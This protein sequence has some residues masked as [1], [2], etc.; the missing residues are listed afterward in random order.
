MADSIKGVV[1]LESKDS[2]QG[3]KDDQVFYTKD[4]LQS[5]RLH[6]TMYIS[7][8]QT[9]GA[10]HLFKEAFAN[11]VDECNN[12]NPHWD[13][14][15]KKISVT[16]YENQRKFVVMDNGR[17][18]PMDILA[19][20][21]MKKHASTKTVAL[22]KAR[23]KK[24]TGL[25]GVGLTVCAAL[26]DYMSMTTYRGNHSKT[27]ELFD[28]ELEEHPEVPLKVFMTGTEIA[29]IPSEKY[30]GP[31]NLTTDIIEDYIRNMSYV[32][33]PDIEVVFTGQKNPNEK[34]ES[35]IKYYTTTYKASGLAAAVKY[36]SSSLEFPPVEPKFV[37]EDFD[38]SIAF[39]YDR[40]LDDT[41]VA[42]FGNY[43]I[44][45]EGGCHERAAIR[46]ISDYFSREAKRQD[47]KSKYEISFDDCRRGLVL[48]VNLEH[49]NPKFE[50]Q[51][52]TKV[53][54]R[55]VETVGKSGLY[56]ALFNVMN[57]NPAIMKKIITY[58]R[59]VARARQESHKIK[60]VST[61]RNTTFLEDAEIEKY[62]TV[63]NRNS[64]GYKELFLC[65]G[66]SA[67][68]A[69]LNCRNAAYQ[70][71]YTVQGVTDNVHDFSL[72]QLLQTKTFKEL[73]TILGTGVGKDFDITKLRY[74]KIIICTDS[75][76][77]GFNITSLLLC[78]FFVFMPE[79]ILQGKLYK[80]MPPL[81]LMDLKS[82][83]RFYAGREWLYDK[84]EY[85]NMLN[86]IIV[87]NCE[88]CLEP[89][90]EVAK[91][92]SKTNQLPKV[93]PLTD[94]QAMKWLGMNSEYKLEL[95]NLGKKAA[96]DPRILET[97]CFLKQRYK[98]PMDF[99]EQ[100]EAVYPEMVFDLKS[101]SLM[102]SWNGEYFTLICDKL[103]DWSS[104]RFLR[105]LGQN[106]TLHVW[107][108]NKKNPDDRFSRVTVG[109]FLTEMERV[110]NVKIDQRFKGLGEADPDLLFRTTANPKY[111]KLLQ[112]SIKDAKQ[113][114]KTFEMLHGKS[115]SLREARRDLI[116]NTHLSYADIDN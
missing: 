77:D 45:T 84:L 74:D 12:K 64:T 111:R 38:L 73:I 82:L 57:N 37:S 54:N 2:V 105:E 62:F 114:T 108:R 72:T 83:R 27:I 21:V 93:V 103:F 96:C 53:D 81:Y 32:L 18:I 15:K 24:I 100:I 63:S 69:I 51:H 86:T 34:R 5:I 98:N 48:A 20:L 110:F 55:D 41:S 107:Y 23:N 25:N 28:G 87:N 9:D 19:D 49:Y 40:S 1:T 65:E 104:A 85:Y 66:D 116:D 26:S 115:A 101:E 91:G 3:I 46:A 17:G 88:I 36:L 75:D 60:G 29:I 22:S 113:A 97:V 33:D 61:K 90:G 30:L 52:K 94:Q 44:T 10:V 102:G 79:I 4:D 42:S 109:E 14:T 70:A 35:K 112:I 99:K 56:Q 59:T 11:A 58:L 39:S 31:I 95:D 50:G 89:E 68:G 80:A 47:P 43:V 8:D 92:K 76:I 71:I 13:K 106:P 6:R 78:F 16:Y 7:S 67:A